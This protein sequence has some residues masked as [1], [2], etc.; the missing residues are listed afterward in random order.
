MLIQDGLAPSEKHKKATAHSPR[1]AL[2][3]PQTSLSD[4]RNIVPFPQGCQVVQYAYP[5]P[6]G[7]IWTPGE[8]SRWLVRDHCSCVPRLT[9]LSTIG[10]Y[11][12]QCL[13][14]GIMSH[15]VLN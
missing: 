10:R 3:S 13:V 14:R 1:A 2:P 5:I 7:L 15:H 11:V 4:L 6:D 8:Q 12:A 9:L